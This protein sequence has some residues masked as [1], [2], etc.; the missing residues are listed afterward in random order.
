[1][2]ELKPKPG[3]W[4]VFKAKDG[5]KYMIATVECS[6]CNGLGKVHSSGC[7]GDPMDLGEDC[8]ECEGTGV[9]DVD[10]MDFVDEEDGDGAL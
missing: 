4:R 7:N 5:D 1:M 6:N 2:N 3:P 8:P 10:L 9:I